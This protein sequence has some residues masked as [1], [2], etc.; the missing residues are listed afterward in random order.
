MRPR[1][2][3]A[4]AAVRDSIIV[5]GGRDDSS[6]VDGSVENFPRSRLSAV[7]RGDQLYIFGVLKSKLF[8]LLEIVSDFFSIPVFLDLVGKRRKNNFPDL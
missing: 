5:A 7:G 8:N 6:N 4:A 2:S 3:F 1:R